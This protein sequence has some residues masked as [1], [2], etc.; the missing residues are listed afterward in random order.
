MLIEEE[1][2][3]IEIPDGQVPLA[4]APKT[5]DLS[6]LWAVISG[7]SLGGAAFLGRKRREDA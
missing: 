7:L 1:D 4:E 5:G 6:M 2:T 3:E